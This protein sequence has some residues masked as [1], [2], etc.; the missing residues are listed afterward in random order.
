MEQRKTGFVK[1]KT[2]RSSSHEVLHVSEGCWLG[3]L[4]LVRTIMKMEDADYQNGLVSFKVRMQMV[5][6]T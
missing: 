1:G 6:S 5:W 2:T 4:G 3:Q